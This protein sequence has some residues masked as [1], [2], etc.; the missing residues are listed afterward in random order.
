ME[1]RGNQCAPDCV[2]VGC[3][4]HVTRPPSQPSK[5]DN[6]EEEKEIPIEEIPLT[7]M[8]TMF[9]SDHVAYIIGYP[10]GDV[11]PNK[12]M[13]RAEIV[14]VFFRLLRDEVRKEYWTQTNEYSDVNVGNWHNNAI[15]VMSNMGIVS[16]YP[17]GTFR[18]ND[19]VTRAELAAIAARFARKLGI[20][21]YRDVIFNDI[22]AH[23]AEDEIMVAAKL[24]WVSGYNN[25]TYYP[26]NAIT[27]AEFMTIVNRLMERVPESV[28]DI[29]VDVMVRWVDNANP[30]AWYYLA[31]Q[32]ATNSHKPEYKDDKVPGLEFAYEKWV[33][34]IENYD[35]L[36]LEQ[37]WVERYNNPQSD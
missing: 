21:G 12:S 4:G 2:C 37:T 34:M 20:E 3:P 29:L 22:E 1:C 16:G 36:A 6:E 31:V 10:E 33:E 25:G 19:S 13:T 26:D 28:E 35:W 30:S 14:T 23:W 5:P 27:R 7:G 17:D 32:E 11:R 15:S 9:V 24:G 18:P 8:F